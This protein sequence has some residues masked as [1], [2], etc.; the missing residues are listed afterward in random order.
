MTE[1]RRAERA[2]ATLNRINTALAAEHD[3]ERLVQMVTDAGVELTGA[4]VGAFFHN[5][6][7]DSGE[8]LHLFTLSGGERGDFIRL[9]RRVA[10]TCW[11]RSSATR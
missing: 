8:R 3:L 2:I 7:D 9:G 10:P 11:A 6:M 5:V 4:S 1:E